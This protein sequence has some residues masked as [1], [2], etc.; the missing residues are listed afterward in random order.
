M[1]FTA[2]F[3]VG[4]WLVSMG[5]WAGAMIWFGSAFGFEIG[6]RSDYATVLITLCGTVLGLALWIAIVCTQAAP[7]SKIFMFGG[8]D[9][10]RVVLTAVTWALVIAIFVW[11]CTRVRSRDPSKPARTTLR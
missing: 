3:A 6:K 7:F 8:L 4:A 1:C 11:L 9:T 10:L 5:A 2:Y